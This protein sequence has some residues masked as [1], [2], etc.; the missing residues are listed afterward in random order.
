VEARCRKLG[1]PFLQGV[2]DKRSALEEWLSRQGVPPA[3]VVYV[4][5]D[6][7]DVECLRWVGCGVVVA[8]AQP[9][10]RA[11]ARLVLRRPGGRGAVREIVDLILHR[12]EG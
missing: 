2:L 6:V 9:E 8:D 4:G 11:A 3:Q 7:N 1:L 5:N 12:R 10:A